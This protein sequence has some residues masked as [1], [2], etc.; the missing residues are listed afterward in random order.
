MTAIC[1]AVGIAI[2]VASTL[3]VL[4]ICVRSGQISRERGDE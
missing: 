3:L 4:A 2:V 1:W